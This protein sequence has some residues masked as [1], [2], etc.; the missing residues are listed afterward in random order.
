MGRLFFLVAYPLYYR[1]KL[2]KEDRLTMFGFALTIPPGVFHP[3]LYFST[4]ILG[5]Y[6]ASRSLRG[7]SVL[8]MGCGSG[9]L[10]LVAAREGASV[11]AVDVNPLAVE[12]SAKNVELNGMEDRVQVKQSDLFG[13]IHSADRFDLIFWNPPWY[14]HDAA[15]D[16]AKAMDA[17]QDYAVLARFAREAGG[18]LNPGGSILLILTER[19]S[20]EKRILRL[21]TEEGMS[22]NVVQ[23]RQSFFETFRIYELKRDQRD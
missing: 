20:D 15:D 23:Q 14:P 13:A 10:S 6:L 19:A 8:E 7:S 22:A 5:S 4:R 2:R 17:G 12:A 21:F 1:R 9:L 3:R 18:Y 11:T 16:A